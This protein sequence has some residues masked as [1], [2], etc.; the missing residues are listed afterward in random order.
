MSLRHRASSASLNQQMTASSPPDKLLRR[1]S[2]MKPLR[3]IDPG[4][5]QM[6]II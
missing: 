5:I 4:I 2:Y 1:G 6:S 3:R